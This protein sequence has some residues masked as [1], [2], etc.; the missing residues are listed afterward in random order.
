LSLAFAAFNASRA[1]DPFS[2]PGWTVNLGELLVGRGLLI[3]ADIDA[4]VERQLEGERSG[5]NL[6]ALGC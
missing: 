4:A 3:R 2:A 1:V 5:E 6:I